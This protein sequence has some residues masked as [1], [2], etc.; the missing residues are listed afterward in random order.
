MADETQV[1]ADMP[2]PPQ[3]R[4]G[5]TDADLKR[6]MRENTPSFYERYG[7]C[8]VTFGLILIC[9]IVYGVEVVQNGMDTNISSLTLYGM[10]AMYA[11]AIQGPSDWYRFIA[12]MFLHCDVMHLLFNMGALYSV[13]V[14]LEGF[15][16]RWN[17]LL[18]YFV[19]GITGNVVSYAADTM[20]GALAVSAGASTSVF[21]LFVACAL[22]GF[23]SA[24]SRAYFSQYSKGMLS[25]IAL[26]I[27][28]TLLIP[29]ISI[30][31]HLGGAIGGLV[32]M[33]MLPSRNLRVPVP[34]RIIVAVFWVAAVAHVIYH[35]GYV[36]P[37]F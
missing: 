7:S 15:L 19:S 28:Y 11:P 6:I 36:F 21:G 10:G 1:T 26:N 9:V 5:I 14:M 34:V 16:G 23:L 31:G 13:G 24:H 29:S 35:G 2:T 12:P 18:L 3:Q 27:V 8:F 25:V 22:L 20:T 4:E 17:Y 37:L 33:F 30:S 32:A